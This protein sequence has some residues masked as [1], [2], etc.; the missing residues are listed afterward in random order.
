MN[1]ARCR[2]RDKGAIRELLLLLART[3]NMNNR[4]EGV[5]HRDPAL[6]RVAII[7]MVAAREHGRGRGGR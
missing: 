6:N 2:A 3:G 4:D 5:T 1:Y 7:L